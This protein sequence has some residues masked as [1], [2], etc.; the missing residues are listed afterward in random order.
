MLR[1]GC[2]FHET[3]STEAAPNSTAPAVVVVDEP[4]SVT[5]GDDSFAMGLNAFE[6]TIW[7][8][9]GEQAVLYDGDQKTFYEPKRRIPNNVGTAKWTSSL[10]GYKTSYAYKG[11][12]TVDRAGKSTPGGGYGVFK[13]NQL[14]SLGQEVKTMIVEGTWRSDFTPSDVF[15]EIQHGNNVFRIDHVKQETSW[16]DILSAVGVINPGAK[17]RVKMFTSKYDF[18]IEHWAFGG[19]VETMQPQDYQSWKT[20][21]DLRFTGSESRYIQWLDEYGLFAIP[22]I[23][24]FRFE[25]PMQH[26]PDKKFL[27]APLWKMKKQPVTRGEYFF[28]SQTER[29]WKNSRFYLPGVGYVETNEYPM[30]V[31]NKTSGKFV[32]LKV[33]KGEEEST[34]AMTREEVYDTLLLYI[35]DNWDDYLEENGGKILACASWFASLFF[36]P[37]LVDR[38]RYKYLMA[39]RPFEQGVEDIV[40]KEGFMGGSSGLTMMAACSRTPDLPVVAASEKKVFIW[41]KGAGPYTKSHGSRGTIKH[42]ALLPPLVVVSFDD[43]KA[44]TYIYNLDKNRTQKGFANPGITA[45]AASPNGNLLAVAYANAEAPPNLAVFHL[46]NTTLNRLTSRALRYEAKQLVVSNMHGGDARKAIVLL[47][48]VGEERQLAGVQYTPNDTTMLGQ[49][50]PLGTDRLTAMAVTKTGSH[51]I[52]FASSDAAGRYYAGGVTDNQ[53]LTETFRVRWPREVRSVAFTQNDCAVIAAAEGLFVLH[54][55][56]L[57]DGGPI[58]DQE[59]IPDEESDSVQ[60]VQ[61]MT[62]RYDKKEPGR[63]VTLQRNGK[64]VIHNERG[65]SLSG[66]NQT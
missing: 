34:E 6:T 59:S 41:K 62:T 55:A 47:H 63:I 60:V 53:V 58:P 35:S 36:L 57:A 22:D 11:S 16:K 3:L 56:G 4:R 32:P 51:W 46:E 18:S 8:P 1:V 29:G 33:N 37:R 26:T 30:E 9:E 38:V 43:N 42:I 48:R 66:C 40:L 19:K 2:E 52:Y 17:R 25:G 54:K 12:F 14:N 20:F 15:V 50:L 44:E 10:T 61:H 24:A 23:D 27:T 7:T 64:L 65:L 28:K 49:P 13:V 21:L 31:L 39:R 5:Y 45:M